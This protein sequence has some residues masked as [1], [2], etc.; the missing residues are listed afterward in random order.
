MES[1]RSITRILIAEVARAV[2][3]RLVAY[4][5]DRIE[6][7]TLTRPVDFLGPLSQDRPVYSTTVLEADDARDTVQPEE[8]PNSRSDRV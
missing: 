8:S 3:E 4:T 2:N 1:P 5:A 6:K 7:F